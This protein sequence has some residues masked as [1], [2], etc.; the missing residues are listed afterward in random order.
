M[1]I[2]VKMQ[3]FKPEACNFSQ[4]GYRSNLKNWHLFLCR[5][6][7]TCMCTYQSGKTSN[8]NTIFLLNFPMRT[9]YEQSTELY[10]WDVELWMQCFYIGW[11]KIALNIIAINKMYFKIIAYINIV[12]D[13]YKW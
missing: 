1:M 4:G 13:L 10:S 6:D 7:T 8:V 9:I 5:I 3:L 2:I 11:F 12:W